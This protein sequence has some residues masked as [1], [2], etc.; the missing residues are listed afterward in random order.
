MLNQT[1]VDD[2]FIYVLARET[3]THNNIQLDL[4]LDEEE[5]GMLVSEMLK[6]HLIDVADDGRIAVAEGLRQRLLSAS[7]KN[8]TFEQSVAQTMVRKETLRLTQATTFLMDINEVHPYFLQL[9]FN[10]SER[11]AK[12]ILK[13]LQQTK[14]LLHIRNR[15]LLVQGNDASKAVMKRKKVDD[16]RTREKGGQGYYT[17]LQWMLESVL[18]LGMSQDG[19]VTIEQI[20]DLLK[21]SPATA[22]FLLTRLSYM[23]LIQQAK[24]G[25][26]QHK[27]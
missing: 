11:E 24:S 5:T 4:G 14:V 19:H 9:R 7:E 13:R 12:K 18:T 16:E 22:E 2:C 23:P 3:V 1:L 21:V 26:I 8:E 15:W 6:Q 20:I 27:Q 17:N 10:I 25:M